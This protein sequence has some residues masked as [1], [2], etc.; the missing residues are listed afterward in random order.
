MLQYPRQLRRHGTDAV[1]R[2]AQLAVVDSSRPRRGT[3]NVKESLLGV[4]RHKNIVAWRRTQT[5]REVVI[6][7][8]QRGQ[9]L[10]PEYLRALLALVMQDKMAALALR[11][12]SLDVLLALR[13]CQKALDRGI[14]TQFER[15]LPG[16]NGM[17]GTVGS[18]LCVAQHG[19]CIGRVGRGSCPTLTVGQCP[20]SV[21]SANQQRRGISKD[22][23]VFLLEA[24]SAIEIA[25]RLVQIALFQFQLAG[26]EVCGCA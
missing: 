25:T 2:N 1:D 8:F 13:F 4:E 23:C 16:G 22:G 7:R 5:A 20:R 10:P 3:R 11:E 15:V 14:G 9:Y 12:V 26:H 18:L 24:E 19:V 21:P 6:A 17:L